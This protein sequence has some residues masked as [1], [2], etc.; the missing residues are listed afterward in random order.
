MRSVVVTTELSVH[1]HLCHLSVAWLWFLCETGRGQDKL[2]IFRSGRF[3]SSCLC[4]PLAPSLCVSTTLSLHPS[5]AAAGHYSYVTSFHGSVATGARPYTGVGQALVAMARREGVRGLQR[6]LAAASLL[7]F[8]NVAT[9]FGV[10]GAGK[11]FS[12]SQTGSA[13]PEMAMQH[14]GHIALGGVAGAAAAVV[15]NPFF[16]L[17][18]R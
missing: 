9:R 4:L 13:A 18:T 7:Q 1:T 17:K 2:A 3:S 11:R 8:T 12:P 16:L 6:G 10:Y 5:T 15:S 14:M